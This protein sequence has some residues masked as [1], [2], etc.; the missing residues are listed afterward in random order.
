MVKQPTFVTTEHFDEVIGTVQEKLTKL[1]KL[2]DQMDWLIG[3]YKSHDEEHTLL[4][5]Q[6]SEHSDRL[7]TIEEKLHITI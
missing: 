5:G 7:E 3:K 2:S 4:N 1:D 6:V